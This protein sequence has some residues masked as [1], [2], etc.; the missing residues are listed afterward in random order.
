MVL[1][2]LIVIHHY[3]TFTCSA[4]INSDLHM[5]RKDEDVKFEVSY[6]TKEE[7]ELDD[8]SPL[9]WSQLAKK[10]VYSLLN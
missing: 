4:V 1:E 9:A 2:K 7:Y 10:L 5:Q 8:L 6:T 3:S